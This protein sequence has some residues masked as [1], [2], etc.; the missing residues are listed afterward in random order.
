M[1]CRHAGSGYGRICVISIRSRWRQACPF[2]EITWT[3]R[4]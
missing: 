2:Q 1:R 4:R 3:A